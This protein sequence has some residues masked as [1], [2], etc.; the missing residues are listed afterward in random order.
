V[1]LATPPGLGAVSVIRMSGDASIDVCDRVFRGRRR[2]SQAKDRSILL[3]DVV[4]RDGS[5][6]DQV[7]VLLM[8]GP[9]SLTGE[10]VVEISC[11]GGLLAPRLVLKRLIEEGA[12]P[13]VPGEFTKRAFLN[14]KIDLTQAEAVGE[15]VHAS[16]E[17]A[18]KAAVRQLEGE[19]SS[20]LRGIERR[21]LDWLTVIEANIDF[22]EDEIEQVD[23]V[24]LKD[25][26]DA[27]AGDLSSLLSTYEQG[28]YIKEGLDVVIVGRPNVGK[29]SLFN[30]LLG[31]DRVIV[32]ELPGTTRDV[33]DGIFSVDGVVLRVHDTAGMRAVSGVLEQEAVRRTER[34]VDEADIAL[35]VVD[36]STP[37]SSRDHQILE[38]VSAKPHMIVANKID[39]DEKA[40]TLALERP[41]RIS[42]LKGWGL[43]DLLEQLTALAHAQI[44]D[45]GYDIIVSERHAQSIKETL[46][47]VS[48]ARRSVGDGLPIEFTASDLRIGLDCLGDVTGRKVTSRVLDQIFSKF[49]I[50]K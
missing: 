37:L 22:T 45:L 23:T 24:K 6:I 26:L 15:I 33:V 47:S 40:D 43:T 31:K 17:K 30:R 3:G 32:S 49:C 20:R 50:G 28:R 46:G 4:S 42:A 8:R 16:S 36:V 27:I 48:R 9:R 7:L 18:L 25:D 2:L 21:L 39:L 35:V 11:H 44:G 38:E 19:L 34:A 5:A 41:M 10:D 29:S 14:G 13:A 1:A 12:R